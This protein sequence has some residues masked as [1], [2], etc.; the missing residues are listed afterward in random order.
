MKKR[1]AIICGTRPEAI[2]LAPLMLEARRRDSLEPF[3]ISSGQQSS[4]CD[5]CLAHF[6]LVPDQRITLNLCAETMASS[7]LSEMIAKIER[8]II[9]LQPHRIICH[10]DTTTALAAAL[11]GFY[12]KKPV[13]HV[14]AGLRTNTIASP[15]P[16]EMHRILISK[17]ATEH[18]APTKSARDNLTKECIPHDKIRITGNTSIDALKY[19]CAKHPIESSQLSDKPVASG[20]RRRR[21]LVTCHRRENIGKPQANLAEALETIAL[22][23]DVEVV[24][25]RHVNKSNSPLLLSSN[26]TTRDCLSYVDFI[27]LMRSSHLIITDSGGLQEEAPP[28]GVPAIIFRDYT[29]RAE[30]IEANASRLVGTDG[31]T[32]VQHVNQLLTCQTTYNQMAKS[33]NVFGDGY[34]ARR[35]CDW[36]EEMSP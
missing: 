34:A 22:R 6:D 27:A 9:N 19:I 7:I 32:L 3:L 31:L 14:E 18:C 24:Y 11:A 26:I 2:K 23:T 15:W 36:L 8:L 4:A 21:I 13:L 28:L 16:E 20:E 25:V 5:D 17:L 30:A 33:R 10:G 1:L 35:I 29:E 12:A